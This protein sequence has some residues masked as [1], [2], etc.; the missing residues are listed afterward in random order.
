VTRSPA[1]ATAE[2]GSDPPLGEVLDFLRWLWAVDH[3]LERAGCR[4][5]TRLGVTGPQRLVIRLVGRFPG[6]RPGRLAAIM[7]LHPS[8]VSGLLA[9]LERRGLVV[10]RPD[11]RDGRRVRLGLSARGRALDVP[12]EGTIEAAV[13]KVLTS[14]PPSRIAAAREVLGALAGALLADRSDDATT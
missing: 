2:L 14:F 6:I 12:A 4:M 5:E 10:R 11:P 7:H 3:G 8:T 9:R 1:L 13:A